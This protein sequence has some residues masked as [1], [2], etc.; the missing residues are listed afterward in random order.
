MKSIANLSE[1]ERLVLE[2]LKSGIQRELPGCSFRLTV[3]GSKARGDAD[4]DSDT[5]VLVEVDIPHISFA[6]KRRLQRIAGEISLESGSCSVSLSSISIPGKKRAT[7]RYSRTYG[8]K[9]SRYE[10][11]RG[12]GIDGQARR[13]LAATE[14]L[15]QQD[16]SDFAVSRAYYAMFYAAQALLLTRNVR[17]IKHSDIIAAFNERF[18]RGGELP[19]KLFLFLRDAFEDRAEGD[20]GLAEVSREQASTNISAGASLSKRSRT[21]YPSGLKRPRMADGA[22]QLSQAASSTAMARRLPRSRR[23]A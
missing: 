13:S 2:E 17:R 15:L 20:Y 4:P 7:T 1:E 16:Y 6:E 10:S 18:I 3:F 19:R 12:R 5:D 14:L 9:E 23:A 8:K 11:K 22:I 21:R